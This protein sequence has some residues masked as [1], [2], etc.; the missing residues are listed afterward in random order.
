MFKEIIFIPIIIMLPFIINVIMH[1]AITIFLYTNLIFSLFLLLTDNMKY[2]SDIEE[3]HNSNVIFNH[4]AL[5]SCGYDEFIK[6]LTIFNNN[7]YNNSIFKYVI[8]LKNYCFGTNTNNINT[9]S[10]FMNNPHSPSIP[11]GSK[12]N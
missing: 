1:F 6:N 3:L 5:T 12:H 4:N 10:P 8:K 7:Y 11:F 9:S 2:T